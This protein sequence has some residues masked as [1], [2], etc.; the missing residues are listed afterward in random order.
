MEPPLD[1]RPSDCILRPPATFFGAEVGD[2]ADLRRG[3][4]ACCGVFCDHFGSGI[5]GGRF[6]ARQLRYCSSDPW[7]RA[8]LSINADDIVDVGDLNVYPL[9]PVR[10]GAVLRDR[11]GRIVSAGARPFI[12]SGGSGVSPAI[13]A[14]VS[15]AIGSSDLKAIRVSRFRDRDHADSN[16][17]LVA[18]A[19]QAPS[20]TVQVL[21]GRES[22]LRWFPNSRAV[23][24]DGSLLADGAP[25]FLSVD[26]DILQPVYGDTGRYGGLDGDRPGDVRAMAEA[27]RHRRIV[28]VE[29]TGHL[30]NFELHGRAVTNFTVAICVSLIDLLRASQP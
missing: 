21:A 11:V 12:A 14:G 30:P 29:V 17:P 10:L 25:T 1:L 20:R 5:P 27:L 22:S 16:G 6:F 23:V 2:L 19:S 9:E 26:A 8:A 3:K 15:D 18:P 7:T 13:V 4:V 24:N 28:G